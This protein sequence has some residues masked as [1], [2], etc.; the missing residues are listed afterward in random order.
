M[1]KKTLLLLSKTLSADEFGKFFI[2]CKPHFINIAFSYVHDIDIAKDIVTDSFVHLWEHR[3]DLNWDVNANIKGYLYSCVKTRCISNLRER[4]THLK[5]DSEL[6]RV[7]Q[8]KLESSIQ[9]LGNDELSEKLF[10]SEIIDI[11]LKELNQMPEQTK[12]IFLAS[13][14]EGLTRQQIADIYHIPVRKVI[15]EIQKTLKVLRLALGDYLCWILFLLVNYN[16]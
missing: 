1:Q 16:K 9:T 14:R 2:E 15:D 11:F 3:N 4:Q 13:R 8:W 6:S 12:A 10:R 5:V 7:A